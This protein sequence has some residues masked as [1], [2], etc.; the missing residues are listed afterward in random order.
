MH[1]LV[2]TTRIIHVLFYK[3]TIC[4]RGA[5]TEKDWLDDFIS[6]GIRVIFGFTV[7]YHA[8]VIISTAQRIEKKRERD[9]IST[10]CHVTVQAVA[11]IQITTEK[12][13]EQD[14][15]WRWTK[16]EY[17]HHRVTVHSFPVMASL[18]A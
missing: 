16:I 7:H 8:G 18:V 11:I 15:E 12:T 2:P 6:K 13:N 5:K 4:R 3:E 10:I 14:L 9:W 17:F 1:D